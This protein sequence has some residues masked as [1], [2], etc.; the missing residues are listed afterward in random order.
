MEIS[1]EVLK[2][3]GWV[4]RSGFYWE[5]PWVTECDELSNRGLSWRLNYIAP[6]RAL[7]ID[8]YER[9]SFEWERCYQ[10]PCHTKE[11]L[12]HIMEMF[13]LNNKSQYYKE[14]DAP[15]SDNVGPYER[16]SEDYPN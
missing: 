13:K 2:E 15:W 5:L 4:F 1:K 8:C 7:H 9:N 12:L 10:G 14:N 16:L 6:D 11:E 3:A